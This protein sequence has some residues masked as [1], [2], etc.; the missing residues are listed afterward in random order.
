MCLSG[1]SDPLCVFF[2]TR[3]WKD[4]SIFDF[5]TQVGKENSNFFEDLREEMILIMGILATPPEIRPYDQ[6]LLTIGFP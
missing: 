2:N 4:E 3:S 5:R 6:G 1:F